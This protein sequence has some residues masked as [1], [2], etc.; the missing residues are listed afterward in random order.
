MCI[1]DRITRARE[2]LY[3]CNATSRMLYGHTTYNRPS[4]F[5]QDIPAQ[6]LDVDNRSS[7]P[8]YGGASYSFGGS[9]Y[10]AAEETPAR[11]AVSSPAH[12]ATKATRSVFSAPKAAPCTLKAGDVVRHG[13]FG[14]GVVQKVTPMGNDSLLEIRFEGVGVKKIMNNFAK[15]TKT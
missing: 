12:T 4:R 2:E 6:L 8:T 1:R 10:T 11:P 15:L 9:R 3:I 14:V 7:R 5:L 13:T